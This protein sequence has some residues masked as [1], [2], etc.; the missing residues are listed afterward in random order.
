[1]KN[2]LQ[3]IR[4]QQNSN[5]SAVQIVHTIGIAV[6]GLLAGYLSKVLD[7]ITFDLPYWME[8]FDIR[9][10]LGRLSVW[11]FAALVIAIYSGSALRAGIR[12]FLFFAAMLCGYYSYTVLVAGFFP[13]SY[14]MIWCALTVASFFLAFVCW[15][16]K[17]QGR[18][19]LFLSAAI[20]SVFFAQGF[21]FGAFYIYVAYQGLELVIW[22]LSI[23]VLYQNPKQ[24]VQMVCLSFPLVILGGQVLPGLYFW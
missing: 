5:N 12:V 9:N 8:Y 14:V 7:C 16:A 19:S 6:I 4:S 11:M 17:G 2:W 24:V 20:V 22:L 21:S 3:T 1:M 18:L 13:K 15:Y 23:A 10:F